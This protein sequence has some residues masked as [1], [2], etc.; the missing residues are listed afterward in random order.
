MVEIIEENI[1][2]KHI[3]KLSGIRQL[4]VEMMGIAPM[5]IIKTIEYPTCLVKSDCSTT[6]RT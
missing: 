5:S 1:I 4:L 2:T 3:K 6:G